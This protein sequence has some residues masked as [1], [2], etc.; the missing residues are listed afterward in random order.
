MPF[1]LDVR[2]ADVP[3]GVTQ[4]FS[5]FLFLSRERRFQPSLSLVYR[6]AEFLCT[7]ELIALHSLVMFLFVFIII[8]IF[9]LDYNN[10]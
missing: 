2:L 5:T 8:I 10:V 4:N 3:A 9:L 6:E 7:H 1:I